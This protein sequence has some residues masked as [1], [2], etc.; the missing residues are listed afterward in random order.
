MMRAE[1]KLSDKRFLVIQILV[2]FWVVA[3]GYRLVKLQVKDHDSLRARAERQ[4]QAA[5]D[6]SPM[7]GIVYDPLNHPVPY[8]ELPA[9]VHG[10]DALF[11][12][13]LVNN[14]TDSISPLKLK[15]YL[16][17]GK[18]VITTPMAEALPHRP[19][20]EVPASIEQWEQFG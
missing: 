9:L 12:P 5:I 1:H 6:L 4:Q 19:D 18:P 8:A 10:L 2:I 14:F 20:V 16:A 15:E 13:Y 11:I 17:T 3:I 7:R